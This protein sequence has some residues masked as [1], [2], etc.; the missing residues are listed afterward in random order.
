MILLI[1]VEA[2]QNRRNDFLQIA[3][4]ERERVVVERAAAAVKHFTVMTT[5]E[6][7]SCNCECL[8]LEVIIMI[9]ILNGL[10]ATN[11][12]RSDR[13]LNSRKS[14]LLTPKEYLFFEKSGPIPA[15]FMFI[16]VLFGF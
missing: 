9:I 5:S 11:R 2:N 7:F 13:E 10:A 8:S 12:D 15:S 16:F 3:D 6:F 14:N 4:R 1:T